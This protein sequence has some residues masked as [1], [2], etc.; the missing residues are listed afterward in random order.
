G[1]RIVSH[2]HPSSPGVR[3]VSQETRVQSMPRGG[4]APVAAGDPC[5]IVLFGAS[6]DLTKRLLIPT[7]YNLACDGLLP[8]RFAV[9]GFARDELST[10][11]F[12]TRM[13]AAIEQFN[14]RKGV[15]AAVWGHIVERLYYLQGDFADPAAYRRLTEKLAEV[16]PR[17]G[18]GGN[19]LFYFAV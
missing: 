5:T 9:I 15:D 13:S 3:T 1:S 19:I 7:L 11:E 2:S 12:R 14:T 4:T 18:T 10:E 16:Q 17:H 6:G 8:E